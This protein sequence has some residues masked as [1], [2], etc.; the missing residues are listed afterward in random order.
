MNPAFFVWGGM[1]WLAGCLWNETILTNLCLL[2][3]YIILW[4]F[5]DSLNQI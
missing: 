2:V 5:L 4:P 3:L 1:F